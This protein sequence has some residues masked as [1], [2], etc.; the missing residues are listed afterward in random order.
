MNQTCHD[1]VDLT[2]CFQD[3]VILYGICV[4]FLVLA[5]LE[6]VVTKRNRRPSVQFSVLNVTK[7]VSS[8]YLS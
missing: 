1:E 7:I 2:L 4:M 6:C 5:L 3:T 8:V